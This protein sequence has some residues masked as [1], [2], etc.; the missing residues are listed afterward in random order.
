M[1]DAQSLLDQLSLLPNGITTKDV[2]NLIGE[3][4][5][6]DLTNLIDALINNDPELLLVNCN[7]LYDM[8]Y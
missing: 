4:S 6:H 1:R 2:Q 3:V 5:E 7:N 8:R